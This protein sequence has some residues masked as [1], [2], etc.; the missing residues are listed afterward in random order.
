M[1][2]IKLL[3]EILS[4]RAQKRAI[5][6]QGAEKLHNDSTHSLIK[7]KSHDAA[8]KYGANT[9]WCFQGKDQ[10]S[11]WAFD[12]YHEK[13]PIYVLHD[14]VENKKYAFHPATHEYMSEKNEEL[15]GTTLCHLHDKFESVKKHF[16]KNP[17]F[18]KNT[19]P[20]KLLDHMMQHVEKAHDEDYHAGTHA[21]ATHPRADDNLKDHAEYYG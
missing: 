12:D 3:I 20:K 13:G 4:K 21:F 14:K 2:A 6:E 15:A 7:L 8:C 5:K 1:R 11:K 17:L 10:M 9:K 18:N 19:H 16:G